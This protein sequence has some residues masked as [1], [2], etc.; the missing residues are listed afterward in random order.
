MP[1]RAPPLDSFEKV[2]EA[3]FNDVVRLAN[4]NVR[5]EKEL[6]VSTA[7]VWYWSY[8][9]EST[10][11][12]VVALRESVKRNSMLV[13]VFR[14]MTLPKHHFCSYQTWEETVAAVSS[15]K[16]VALTTLRHAQYLASHFCRHSQVNNHNTFLGNL[17]VW[18]INLGKGSGLGAFILHNSTANQHI[19]FVM[20]STTSNHPI[21][22]YRRLLD[23]SILLQYQHLLL[24]IERTLKAPRIMNKTI[25]PSDT[26]DLTEHFVALRLPH[27]Y[28]LNVRKRLR[29]SSKR[30][31][32]FSS[33]CSRPHSEHDLRAG[34]TVRALH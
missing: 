23:E 14:R 6:N 31:P 27:L 3:L 30:R 25:C 13:L 21:F 12:L 33:H 17:N 1:P 2:V 32:S 8:L 5:V 4:R 18:P 20:S 26:S 29:Y 9:Q 34:E 24:L 7:N 15:G 28:G 22:P 19:K 16:A 11:P 10:E